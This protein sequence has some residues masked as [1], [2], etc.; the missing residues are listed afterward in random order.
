M[1]VAGF[2]RSSINK[3]EYGVLPVMA[4]ANE[5]KE[6]SLL[7]LIPNIEFVNTAALLSA[8]LTISPFFGKVKIS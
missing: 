1:L 7:V 8:K 6:L 2:L 4:L 3:S 5:L